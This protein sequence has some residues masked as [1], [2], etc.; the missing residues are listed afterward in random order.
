[1]GRCSVTTSNITFGAVLDDLVARADEAFRA[2]HRRIFADDD[3]AVNR[4]LVVETTDASLVG[5]VATL[6]LITPWRLNG[7][8][9]PA[10][11]TGPRELL[12]AGGLRPVHR[13]DVAPLG[14]YWA[15]AL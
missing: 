6:V 8:I 12:V 5:D 15:V 10:D 13:G 11:G 3:A 1:M 9:V 14:V 4:N 2:V 7:L